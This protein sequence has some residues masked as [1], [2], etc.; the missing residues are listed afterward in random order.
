[1]QEP[2]GIFVDRAREDLSRYA[3]T[4]WCPSTPAQNYRLQVESQARSLGSIRQRRC[5]PSKHQ[6]WIGPTLQ[7]PPFQCVFNQQ[8]GGGNP[9]Q[10]LVAALHNSHNQI[11]R[12]MK[13]S[14]DQGPS[15]FP[16]VS[17]TQSKALLKAPAGSL[18]HGEKLRALEQKVPLINQ[19]TRHRYLSRD[20]CKS[21]S[22]TAGKNRRRR[23]CT[24][25]WSS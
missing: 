21:G 12:P 22:H 10:T 15:T 16:S 25:G 4:L 2:A 18:L 3:L 1:M 19:K 17:E 13:D 11:F 7:P 20:N 14:R 8:R 5:P 23:T 24:K 6:G 9:H